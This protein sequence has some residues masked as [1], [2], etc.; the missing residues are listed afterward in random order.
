MGSICDPMPAK[1]TARPRL[2]RL[3]IVFEPPLYSEI[4]YLAKSIGLGLAPCARM[5]VIEALATRAAFPP[6]LS[7][8]QRLKQ[9]QAGATPTAPRQPRRR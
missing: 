6:M 8:T 3:T 4:E 9:L 5:L 7:A 1:R 2:H